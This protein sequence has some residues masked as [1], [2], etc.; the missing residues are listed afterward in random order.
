MTIVDHKNTLPDFTFRTNR[1][2]N[3]IK[4]LKS[5]I[6]SIIR[7]LNVNKAHVSDNI[8]IRVFKICDELIISPLL[9]TF[10][11]ALRSGIYPTNWKKPM[12]YISIKSILHIC[13]KYNRYWKNASLTPFFHILK[14]TIYS[15]R[16]NQDFLKNIFVYPSLNLFSKMQHSQLHVRYVETH[17]K[18]CSRN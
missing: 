8:S 3:N 9:I 16:F 1:K 14:T 10:E 6:L 5:E 2:L 15:L 4:F 12:S 13:E 17:E 7:A 11:T 18:N